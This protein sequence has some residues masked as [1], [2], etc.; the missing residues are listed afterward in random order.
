MVATASYSVEFLFCL[1]GLQ[2]G[3]LE[4]LNNA[5]VMKVVIVFSLVETAP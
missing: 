1:P 5:M 4:A 2:V 3:C